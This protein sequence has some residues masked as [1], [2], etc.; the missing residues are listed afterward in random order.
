MSNEISGGILTSKDIGK[1]RQDLKGIIIAP[2]DSQKCKGIG[3]NL[4]PTEFCYSV[5]KSGCCQSTNRTRKYM[6][7]FLRTTRS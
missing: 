5:R 3:Y 4:S 2:F 1:C 6:C 7:G